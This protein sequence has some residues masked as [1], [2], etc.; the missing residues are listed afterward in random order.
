MCCFLFLF[1]FSFALFF[2]L[3]FGSCRPSVVARK[4]EHTLHRDRYPRTPLWCQHA[5]SAANSAVQDRSKAIFPWF[6]AQRCCLPACL[7]P[8]ALQSRCCLTLGVSSVTGGQA[9]KGIPLQRSWEVASRKALGINL[10][11]EIKRH[12]GIREP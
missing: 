8:N 2:L 5:S 7:T 4:S 12:G 10:P 11:Q 1:F 6:Q 9:R 3:I